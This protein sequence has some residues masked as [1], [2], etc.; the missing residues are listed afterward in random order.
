MGD[1]L[2]RLSAMIP[3]R[4]RCQ[5]YSL[6]ADCLKPRAI[7]APLVMNNCHHLAPKGGN[8]GDAV[9]NPQ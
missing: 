2:E 7:N 9:A 4:E 3:A 8:M 6:L 5:E 1:R